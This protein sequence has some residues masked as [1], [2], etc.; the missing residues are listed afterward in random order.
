M[1]IADRVNALQIIVGAR[2]HK[3]VF[4]FQFVAKVPTDVEDVFL[5]R[6]VI[7]GAT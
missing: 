3:D 5:S 7:P 4:L 6:L 2:K 1:T